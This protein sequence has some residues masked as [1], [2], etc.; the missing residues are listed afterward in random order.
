MNRESVIKAIYD[1]K[2]IAIVRGLRYESIEPFARAV[3]RGGIALIEVTFIQDDPASWQEIA[4]SIELLNRLGVIA[5]AGTVMTEEQL[6]I[7]AAAGANYIISPNTDPV[8]IKKTRELSLVS[9][10]GAFTPTEVSNAYNCGADF[11]K[12][13]PASALGPAYIK[14]I[15]APL[16]HIPLLAVGGVTPEVLPEYIKAGCAGAGV[17]GNMVKRELIEKGDFE[18]IEASAAAYARAAGIV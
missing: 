16:K 2:V 12:L 9:I 1:K 13:F 5:G 4:R 7:A 8:I 14:A 3:L 17:G 6:A 15:K 11:V 18:A 10:P